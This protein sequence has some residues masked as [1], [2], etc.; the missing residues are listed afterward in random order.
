M[1]NLPD[2]IARSLAP[3]VP[4]QRLNDDD[5]YVIDL[6]A[7]KIIEEIGASSPSASAARV[8]GLNVKPGQA[9]LGGLQ[10]RSLGVL[11]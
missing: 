7:K 3:F 11:V 10:A 4:P 2:A 1:N 9:L 6:R 5:L 8:N